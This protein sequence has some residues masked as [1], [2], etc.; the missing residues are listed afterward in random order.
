MSALL[1]GGAL[2]MIR[3]PSSALSVTPRPAVSPRLPLTVEHFP[4]S[5]GL[6]LQVISAACAVSG[7][8]STMATRSLCTAH[9]L[10]AF[11]RPFRQEQDR[12]HGDGDGG[13]QPL[14]GGAVAA[15]AVVQCALQ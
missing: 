11:A 3:V 8:S 1:P 7:R 14:N 9:F 6:F 5:A 12:D 13:E 2:I 4:V 15:Q 10:Q